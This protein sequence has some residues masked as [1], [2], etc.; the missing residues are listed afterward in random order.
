MNFYYV[1]T[2]PGPDLKVTNKDK[3]FVISTVYP[4]KN[5]DIKDLD[6][7]IN[8]DDFNLDKNEMDRK[9][10]KMK[11]LESKQN[12]D[13][14]GEKKLEKINDT[15][16]E[17]KSLINTTNENLLKLGSKAREAIPESIKNTITKI[18]ETNS[19]P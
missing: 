11:N 2:S 6:N 5:S 7:Q 1:F 4:G 16:D 14:E 8:N 19:L 12:L 15:I 17:M 18:Y 13:R 3:L 9:S 10:N